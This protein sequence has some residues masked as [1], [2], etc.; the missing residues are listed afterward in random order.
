MFAGSRLCCSLPPGGHGFDEFFVLEVSLDDVFDQ[1]L[2]VILIPYPIHPGWF[3]P[4][5]NLLKLDWVDKIAY[6]KLSVTV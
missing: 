1:L 3:F 6:N 5:K 4:E 2:I